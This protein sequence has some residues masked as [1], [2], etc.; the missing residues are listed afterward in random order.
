MSSLFSYFFDLVY[1]NL[2][3]LCS[4][5]L[6]KAEKY[7]CFHCRSDIPTTKYH[8]TPDNPVEK[9][10]WGKVPLT[11]GSSYF[12]F[13]KGSDYQKLIHEL[14]YRGNREL[15]IELGRMAGAELKESSAFASADYIVPVPLHYK[16]EAKRGFNQSLMIALGMSE[17]LNI[18]VAD[19][20]LVRNLP[21]ETQT[22]KSVY[23]RYE[24]TAGIF[25]L[26]QKEEC[27]EKHILLVDDVLTTGS[28]L[29]ACAAAL[30]Q[31]EGVK[32]SVFTLALAL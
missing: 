31:C 6:M 29:E 8:L 17:T 13:Q 28:T 14:K 9:R 27:E 5:N 2:C 15:G 30:L 7:I 11:A 10:F 19:K 3:L 22:R 23:E 12:F 4:E 18:P 32:V 25:S 20:M 24:N 26:R 21:S 16:K 1:P